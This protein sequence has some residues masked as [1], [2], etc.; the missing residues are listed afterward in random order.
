MKRSAIRQALSLQAEAG[1][2]AVLEDFVSTD[3]KVKATAELL[4]KMK[5]EGNILLAVAA[6]D[7]MTERATRNLSG[8]KAVTATYL[9]VYDIMNAD[10]IVITEK[11]LDII[12][13]WLGEEK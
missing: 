13:S 10:Q 3:G 1:R 6:K 2:I 12:K 4:T 7:S 11:A 9:N 5:L 8:L